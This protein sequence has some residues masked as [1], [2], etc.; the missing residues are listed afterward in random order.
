MLFANGI[1]SLETIPELLLEHPKNRGNSIFIPWQT[2][3]FN[4]RSSLKL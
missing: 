3:E 2:R 4:H 1:A